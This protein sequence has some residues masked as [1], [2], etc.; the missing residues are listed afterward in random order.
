MT[1]GSGS[2]IA[3]M[4]DALLAVGGRVMAWTPI[5]KDAFLYGGSAIFAVMTALFAV[6]AD[7]RAWGE[8]AAISYGLAAAICLWAL[9]TS[10]RET[11]EERSFSLLRRFI[12]VGV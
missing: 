10:R 2:T 9:I 12:L 1:R 3:E 6:S 8:M 5:G 7:Y 4:Q 11:K